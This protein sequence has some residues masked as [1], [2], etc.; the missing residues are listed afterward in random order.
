M[1]TSV[2]KKVA[3]EQNQEKDYRSSL[4]AVHIA[5]RDDLGKG[6]DPVVYLV[7]SPPLNWN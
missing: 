1:E 2:N 6:D 7:S 3:A 5:V 4:G